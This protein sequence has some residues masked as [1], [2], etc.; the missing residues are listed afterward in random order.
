[1]T[2]RP[3]YADGDAV[4]KRPARTGS[5][6]VLGFRVATFENAAHAQHVA[7]ALNAAALPG[8]L[9]MAEERWRQMEVEG[10]DDAHDDEHEEHELAVA[11]AAYLLHTADMDF[12]WP[13]DRE[14]WKP[15]T[16]R[17]DLTKAGALI[18]AECDRLDRLALLTED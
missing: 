5:G 8:L 9:A 18:L 2:E 13:W 15:T 17:R 1:M 4:F 11:A 14:W 10:F 12:Y 3:Y 7:A 6:V 16:P